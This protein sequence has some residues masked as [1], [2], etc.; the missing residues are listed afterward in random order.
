[1]KAHAKKEMFTSSSSRLPVITSCMISY[2]AAPKCGTNNEQ[3]SREIILSLYTLSCS[4]A[5]PPYYKVCEASQ[6]GSIMWWRQ[7]KKLY[8]QNWKKCQV[9][10]TH[11][12]CG[13]HGSSWNMG[14]GVHTETSLPSVMLQYQGWRVHS[15]FIWSKQIQKY[16]LCSS[17]VLEIY[18]NNFRLAELLEWVWFS[19]KKIEVQTSIKKLVPH[20]LL[21]TANVTCYSRLVSRL[22]ILPMELNMCMLPW[23]LCETS[24][25]TLQ[26]GW[27]WSLL[28]WFNKCFTYLS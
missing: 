8:G 3:E 5:H 18:R 24:F 9:Y 22:L 20:T 26:R 1:M 17:G 11:S 27:R 6:V 7:S 15:E 23:Q 13:I 12:C 16:L 4:P 25:T 2:P 19:G 14:W 10:C 28:K 21:C